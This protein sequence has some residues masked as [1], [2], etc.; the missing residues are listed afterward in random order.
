MALT[1]PAA[2]IIKASV[3]L[4]TYDL[5]GKIFSGGGSKPVY[6]KLDV[7]D[8]DTPIDAVIPESVIMDTI[9]PITGNWQNVS[10]EV[11]P[12][13][14][15]S[16]L[17]VKFRFKHPIAVNTYATNG[18]SDVFSSGAIKFS[19]LYFMINGIKQ[20]LSYGV[21]LE[22][23]WDYVF[24][25]MQYCCNGKYKPALYSAGINCGS[26]TCPIVPEPSPSGSTTGLPSGSTSNL[27]SSSTSNLPSGS[28][29][30]LPSLLSNVAFDLSPRTITTIIL[31]ILF[32]FVLILAIVFGVV[33]Y[34]KK[35]TSN[36]EAKA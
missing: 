34:R 23:A 35:S 15:N 10:M 16:G 12:E 13:I 30:N 22:V 2:I 25:R 27:P 24:A 17:N 5:D 3:P 20:P 18:S 6:V 33:E 7:R 1:V 19:D 9:D 31:V 11:N 29:T 4:A 8:S 32:V 26:V 21:K 14:V 36:I 28:T